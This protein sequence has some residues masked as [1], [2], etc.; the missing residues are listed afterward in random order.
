MRQKEQLRQDEGL[1][2]ADLWRQRQA[3]CLRAQV[4]KELLSSGDGELGE[5]E[6]RKG[7]SGQGHGLLGGRCGRHGRRPR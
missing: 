7:G 6:A 3:R 1:G 4:L 2:D 5:E